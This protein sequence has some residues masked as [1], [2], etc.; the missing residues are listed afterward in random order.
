M[1]NGINFES[2]R[3]S[4]QTTPLFFRGLYNAWHTTVE[5]QTSLSQDVA[6]YVDGYMNVQVCG[7]SVSRVV[8]IA[9]CELVQRTARP[10]IIAW[11]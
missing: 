3:G 2:T 7:F 9:E 4:A 6:K 1:S 10:G 5:N 11:L 8:Q